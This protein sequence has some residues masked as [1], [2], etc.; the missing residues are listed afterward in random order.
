MMKPTRI[1][2]SFLMCAAAIFAGE[3]T[4]RRAPGWALPD[5]KMEFHDLMDYRGKVV[6]I[7]FMQTTCEHCANFVPVLQQV[8]QKYGA[9]V[10]VLSIVNGAADDM[11]K[12]KQYVAGHKITYPILFDQGQMEYSYVRKMQ[13]DNP[14][15]FLVDAA[16]TIRN[17]F[18]YG[19]L[20]KSMFE[21]AAMFAEIDKILGP[22]KK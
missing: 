5:T 20:T 10:Q 16:G 15:V 19:P 21:P 8:Q 14:T 7:E 17:D 2:I 13:V 1:L 6:V 3:Q 9:R 22:Q 11:N 12:V 18:S 4:G